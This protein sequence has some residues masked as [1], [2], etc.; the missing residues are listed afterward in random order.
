MTHSTKKGCSLLPPPAFSPAP[1][2]ANS[3]AAQPTPTPSTVSDLFDQIATTLQTYVVMD[4]HQVVAA[5]LWIAMTHVHDGIQV[6]PLALI[7]APEK[8]CGKSQLLTIFGR[9]VANPL[10]AANCSMSFIFRSIE[11]LGPT[12]LIDEA[13]T[14]FKENSELKGIINAGHTRE[15]ASVGRTESNGNGGFVPVLFKVWCA[16]AI[17]GIDMERHLPPATISRCIK[18]TMRRKMSSETVARLRH[19]DPNTFSELASRLVQFGKEHTPIIKRARP[20]LPE[21]LNDREQDNWEPL[22]AIA[23]CAGPDWRTR[24]INAALA[25]SKADRGTSETKNEL[26]ADIRHIF[27]TK[28]VSRITTEDLIKWLI[29]DSEAPW[30]TYNRGTPIS[31]RQLSKLLSSYDPNLKSK[32]V[33]MGPHST[34]KGYELSQFADAFARYLPPAEPSQTD[35]EYARNPNL[36]PPELLD[37]I[38]K[39]YPDYGVGSLDPRPIDPKTGRPIGPSLGIR[40]EDEF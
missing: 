7:S 12:L 18:I 40:T 20:E 5:T 21:V 27:Q 16:K 19:A 25:I 37:A 8:A 9:L 35:T 26:L 29:D 4:E 34:P 36:D 14:F 15:N 30:K 23:E 32:T 10:P 6:S 28:H 2:P 31:A 33:R 13:D 38:R 1:S 17:A 11:S 39:V 22:I 24:A 3:K